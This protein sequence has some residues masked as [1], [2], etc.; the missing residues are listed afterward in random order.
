MDLGIRHDSPCA[1]LKMCNR[2][3]WECTSLYKVDHK[4]ESFQALLQHDCLSGSSCM[5]GIARHSA[6]MI[7]MLSNALVTEHACV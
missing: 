2:T 1:C 6:S 5:T 3:L 4:Q 7:G